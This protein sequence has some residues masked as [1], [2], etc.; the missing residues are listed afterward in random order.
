MKKI[1]L[2]LFCLVTTIV[3]SQNLI[4]NPDFQ[5]GGGSLNSWTFT[6]QGTYII[7]PATIAAT[8]G[9]AAI[10]DGTG[11]FYASL[12]GENGCL[13]QKVAVLPS[14]N[15]SCTLVFRFITTRQTSGYGYAMETTTPLTPPDVTT[16]LNGSSSLKSFCTTNGGVWTE[17]GSLD[18]AN[19]VADPANYTRTFT[20]AT[21]ADAT[22]VYI[23]VGSKGAVSNLQLNTVNLTD[24]GALSINEVEKSQFT[25]YPNP[26][27]NDV[28]IS[29]IQGDFS[30]KIV[31]VSGKIAKS[32]TKQASNTINIS[33]LNA[34]VYFME[35]TN[36][37]NIKQTTKLIKK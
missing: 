33:D 27:N 2:A 14:H 15:Y 11:D 17:F 5:A 13:Y 10:N 3:T 20:F 19:L 1:T 36:S 30:Y 23:S 37:D 32:S 21:P 8:H 31:D 25:V 12:R 29:N 6:T 26:A 28:T 35:I 34:G 9:T 18:N 4:V 16:I 24:T 7:P 22:F